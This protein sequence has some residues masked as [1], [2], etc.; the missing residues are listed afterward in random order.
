MSADEQDVDEGMPSNEDHI[1][2]LFKEIHTRER[3]IVDRMWESVK[4]FS[5][6]H[7]ALI[8]AT[9]T[10][11]AT[12]YGTGKLMP[13]FLVF[14][15]ITSIAVLALGFFDFRRER[16]ADLEHIAILRKIEMHL[17]LHGKLDDKDRYFSND[18][19]L[20]PDDWVDLDKDKIKST[21]DFVENHM[22][23]CRQLRTVKRTYGSLIA[24]AFLV[25]IVIAS[26]S[27]PQ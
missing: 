16:K 13:W 8:G 22:R 20:L 25:I 21:G 7:L 6:L 12:F 2:D 11:M 9:V 24:I 3:H 1:V 19:F 4:F 27:L 18:K 17:G 5:T 15:P 14:L 10:L 26:L 23:G